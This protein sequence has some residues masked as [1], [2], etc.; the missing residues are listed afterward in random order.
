MIG[1]IIGRPT[2]MIGAILSGVVAVA[3]V[4][5]SSALNGSGGGS[6][7]G[8]PLAYHDRCEPIAINLGLNVSYNET[9]MP[10][11]INHRKQ[12]DAG[13]CQ[14]A[15]RHIPVVKTMYSPDLIFF[16]CVIYAPVCAVVENRYRRLGRS[17]R[18]RAPA[19]L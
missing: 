18:A 7:G 16:L 17:A 9:I 8:D 1:V 10:N 4:L 11:S 19:R 3:L 13:G 2:T 5:H 6:G 12:E 14:E 15:H